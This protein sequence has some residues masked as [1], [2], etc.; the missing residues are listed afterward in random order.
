MYLHISSFIFRDDSILLI[1]ILL[2]CQFVSALSRFILKEELLSIAY[3][4]SSIIKDGFIRI[5]K[6]NLDK[7]D[8][9]I[10]NKYEFIRENEES[11]HEDKDDKNK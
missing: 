2:S 8:Y 3:L 1:I 5:A 4:L 10:I 6:M 7:Y 11:Q 9:H